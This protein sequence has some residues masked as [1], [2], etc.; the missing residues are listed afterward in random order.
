VCT[1]VCHKIIFTILVI[2]LMLKD[3]IKYFKLSK[4]VYNDK[5]II[6]VSIFLIRKYDL[7]KMVS[8]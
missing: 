6:T 2:C 5:R 4:L 1:F 3:V 7:K 8:N